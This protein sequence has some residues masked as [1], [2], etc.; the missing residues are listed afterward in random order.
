MKVEVKNGKLVIEIDMQNPHPSKSG[1]TLIVASTNGI[2]PT[3]AQVNGK[4]VKLGLNAF[5]AKD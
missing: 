4:V 5:I 1:K 2:Q 3:T